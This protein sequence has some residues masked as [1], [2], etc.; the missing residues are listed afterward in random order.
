MSYIVYFHRVSKPSI[1]ITVVLVTEML[2]FKQC[3]TYEN[4]AL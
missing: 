4:E 1:K 2:G 3:P